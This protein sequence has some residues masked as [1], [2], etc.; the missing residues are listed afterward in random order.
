MK[1]E[2]LPFK[3]L[4]KQRCGLSFEGISEDNLGKAVEVRMA[5][6]AISEGDR[7]LKLIAA[8]NAEFDELVSMLTINETY[9]FREAEQLS[10]LIAQLLPRMLEKDPQRPVRIMSAGCSSGEEPYSI[11]MALLE[12]H[13]PAMSDRVNIVA[14]DIDQQVLDKA[15]KGI[16][17]PFSFRGLSDELRE[18]Y[19]S[20]QSRHDFQLH[21]DVRRLVSFHPLN[22]LANER[23]PIFQ[24]VDI[25]F[26]RNVSIYFD[27]A[28]RHAI[29]KNLH[30]MMSER[31]ILLVGVAESM[32][33]DLGVFRLV[34]E[35]GLFYFS[36][37]SPPS[38]AMP[39]AG[40]A[41]PRLAPPLSE[42]PTKRVV[43]PGPSADNP[44]VLLAEARRLSRDKRYDEAG[45]LLRGM[46]ERHPE[47]ENREARL[48]LAWIYLQ[49][50]QF[51]QATAL[52]EKI[53]KQDDWSREAMLLLGFAAHW[54]GDREESLRRF[55]QAAYVR[56][57]C[58][59]A[60]Y[61]LGEAHRALG[62]TDMARRAYRMALQY[63]Q[64][65]PEPN[66][67][68][69]LPLDL[70]LGEIRFL[71]EKHAHGTNANGTGRQ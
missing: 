18:R 12:A 8:N 42:R 43:V 34:E 19:F 70:P 36:K 24:D 1:M 51:A 3:E 46:L 63:L 10:L 5:Q 53:L 56:L 14:G 27:T 17:T 59:V 35:Q 54:Q 71:C 61:Y 11:A 67:G 64:G 4:I 41:M 15:R 7:Y 40:I 69:M 66:S 25:V 6:A 47:N 29:L 38:T 52:A 49:R 50:R 22:L 33:N 45:A 20:A 37:E 62:N 30:Q 13:D 31:G 57:D 68:L 32:A 65:D 60:Q 39:S 55:K 48:L 58:W 2:L 23:A 44:K 16:Y 21:Q 9:F 28:T 26:F